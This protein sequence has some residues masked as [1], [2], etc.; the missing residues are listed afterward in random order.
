MRSFKKMKK[1]AAGKYSGY[2][3]QIIAGLREKAIEQ[4]RSRIILAG[5]RIEEL[6]QNELEV[7]VKEE[8]DKIKHRYKGFVAVGLL[9]YAGLN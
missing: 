5:L 6:D 8:E 1:W 9:A 7:I 2:E 4:A 3:D